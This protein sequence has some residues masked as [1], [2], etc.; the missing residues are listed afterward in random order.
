MKKIIENLIKK[1]NVLFPK[2][3]SSN[4]F[5][6]YTLTKYGIKLDKNKLIKKAI[7]EIDSLMKAKAL[8]GSYSLVYDIDE[9]IPNIG[10]DLVTYYRNLNFNVFILDSNIDKRLDSIELYISWK[11][12]KYTKEK[13]KNKN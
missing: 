12:P 6:I 5:D 4:L 8:K 7:E 9:F 1:I 13:N 11:K 2:E 10:N 3:V